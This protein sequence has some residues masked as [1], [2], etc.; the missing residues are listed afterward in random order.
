MLGSWKGFYKYENEKIQKIIGYEKTEFEINIDDFDGL[1]F[2]G[3][4]NDDL[5]TGGMQETGKIVGKITNSKV[6][7]EKSM[8]KNSLIINTKGDRKQTERKHPTI[9]YCGTLS[10][11]KTEITGIWYFKRKLGFLFGFIPIIF[12]PG[13][14]TWKMILKTE[15]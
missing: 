11:D 10:S 9:Y 15:N 2:S 13:K 14:G 4:V 6:S 5:K 7:F 3:K 12:R 1:N 8:P